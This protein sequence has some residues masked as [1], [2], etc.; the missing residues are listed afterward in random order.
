MRILNTLIQIHQANQSLILKQWLLKNQNS[1]MVQL[2]EGIANG[3]WENDIQASLFLYQDACHPNYRRLKT[4]L[5]EKLLML[6][7]FIPI[8][9]KELTCSELRQSRNAFIKAILKQRTSGE[10][11]FEEVGLILSEM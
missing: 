10:E 9:D 4:L 11:I 3:K 2:Y 5:K 7:Q 6:I 8:S 1:K